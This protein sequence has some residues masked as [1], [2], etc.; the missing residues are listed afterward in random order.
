MVVLFTQPFHKPSDPS[1]RFLQIIV[2]ILVERPYVDVPQAY[3]RAASALK[4]EGTNV[5]WGTF[6]KADDQSPHLRKISAF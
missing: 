6:I 2:V 5:A 3:R 4:H 1:G